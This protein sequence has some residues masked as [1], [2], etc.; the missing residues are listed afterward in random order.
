MHAYLHAP[1]EGVSTLEAL[2]YEMPL[3]LTFR[4]VILW[5]GGQMRIFRSLRELRRDNQSMI[6]EVVGSDRD[7]S[8]LEM[9]IEGPASSTH[10]LPYFKTDCKGSFEVANNSLAHAKIRLLLP[11]QQ[12]I[13]LNTDFGAVLEMSGQTR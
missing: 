5:H 4:K 8:A 7:G 13:E 11:G 3:G 10:R 2:F 1:A 6:W 9:R 12:P